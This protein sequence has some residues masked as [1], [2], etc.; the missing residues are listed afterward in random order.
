MKLICKICKSRV[1][2]NPGRGRPIHFICN[3]C[4]SN[5]L[6]E[7]EKHLVRWNKEFKVTLNEN[8]N[9]YGFL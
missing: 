9:R 5:L 2:D 1:I 4:R 3:S 6:K 7:P 8:D